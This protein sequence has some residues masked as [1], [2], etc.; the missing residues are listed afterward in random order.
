M[1]HIQ[2]VTLIILELSVLLII[3]LISSMN[4]KNKFTEQSYNHE[5]TDAC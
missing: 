3:L 5:E 1:Q 2:T 4:V